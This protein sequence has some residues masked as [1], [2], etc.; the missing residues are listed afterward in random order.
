MK[1][2][3]EA[4]SATPK[5]KRQLAEDMGCGTREVELEVQ[6]A[7]MRGVPIYSDTDGY[8]YAQTADEAYL[9]ALRLQRRA[10]NQFLTARAL[11]R[12]A[13]RMEVREMEQQT[14]WSAA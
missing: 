1:T 3:L 7:R 4:L 9:C 2:L 10:A 12:A 14:L 11:R 13:R 8:R 6:D 5:T